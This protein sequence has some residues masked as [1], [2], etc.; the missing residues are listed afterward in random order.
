MAY[1]S[2]SGR[3]RTSARNP[4]AHAI[5]DRCGFRFNHA[6]LHWQH[7]WRGATI[8]NLRLLVC[9]N[10]L[11]LHQEQLRAVVIPADPT[12]IMNAR[13]QDF[14]AASS[15]YRAASVGTVIDPVTGIPMPSTTLRVT[16]DNQSRVVEPYGYPHH[17]KS[18]GLDQNAVMPYSGAVQKVYGR[19]LGVLSVVSDGSATIYVT[20][21]SVHGMQSHDQITVQGLTDP[22][23]CGFFSVT[24][25]TATAFNYQCYGDINT[26]SLA[27]GGTLILTALVGLPRGFADI[28]QILGS[29]L[30]GNPFIQDLI[31]V[32]TADG[33]FYL[34]TGTGF[35]EL[36]VGP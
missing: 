36:E 8:Q 34:E 9:Q 2:I 29:K 21:T 17:G 27:T 11:D 13:V 26:A 24:V 28:A 6:D 5:C 25:T 3:A 4:R 10:C 14:S 35:I 16:G 15:D 19:Q 33:V 12:P 20:C 7:D 23:A 32:E 30:S 31:E 22:N 18:F 1:A